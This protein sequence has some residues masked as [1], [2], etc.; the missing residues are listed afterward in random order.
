M[1]PKPTD[2]CV[3]GHAWIDHDTGADHYCIFKVSIDE[4]WWRRCAC[5]K[6]VPE[7]AK[8]TEPVRIPSPTPR[9]DKEE[10]EALFQ[11]EKGGGYAKAVSA[12][13]ARKL[14]RELFECHLENI[15]FGYAIQTLRLKCGLS[16]DSVDCHGIYLYIDQLQNAS[17][18]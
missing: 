8:E 13:F 6:F 15:G 4:H 5:E 11:N 2:K 16:G 17:K 14:E 7:K 9:T 18:K 10:E 1:K 3:C 12:E